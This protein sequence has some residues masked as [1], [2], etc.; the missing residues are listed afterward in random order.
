MIF[1]GADYCLQVGSDFLRRPTMEA[2]V[3]VFSFSLFLLGPGIL[4][5]YA[6]FAMKKREQRAARISM[7]TAICQSIPSLVAALVA[8]RFGVRLPKD[9]AYLIGAPVL[10]SAAITPLLVGAF[11]VPALLAQ[12]WK[13]SR[14]IKAIRLLPPTGHAFEAIRIEPIAVDEISPSAQAGRPGIP[15]KNRASPRPPS[16]GG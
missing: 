11:F 3:L 7:C 1:V 9:R 14:A 15:V 6:A 5:L 8:F 10:L 12:T 2:R 13:L 4:Y 16:G